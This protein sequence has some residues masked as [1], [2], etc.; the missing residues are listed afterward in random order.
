MPSGRNAGDNAAVR[1]AFAVIPAKAGIQ[2]KSQSKKHQCFRVPRPEAQHSPLD[3]RFRGND[4]REELVR[5]DASGS[6][7]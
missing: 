1:Q 2:C 4:G 6:S 7:I 3:S 5:G